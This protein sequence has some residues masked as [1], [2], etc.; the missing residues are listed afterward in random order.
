MQS[1]T[2][3][4]NAEREFD[5]NK[6]SVS[7]NNANFQKLVHVV[8]KNPDIKDSRSLRSFEHNDERPFLLW[9]LTPLG[10]ALNK[11]NKLVA[12]FLEKVKAENLDLDQEIPNFLTS[13]FGKGKWSPLALF[14]V[15]LCS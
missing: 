6:F 13:T 8:L 4:R 3:K 10:R 1:W 14:V 12:S 15:L 11:A 5:P 2:T 7:N 9:N